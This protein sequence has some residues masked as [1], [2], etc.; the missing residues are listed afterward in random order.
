MLE[1]D[2]RLWNIQFF[3][4]SLLNLVNSLISLKMFHGY[5]NVVIYGN[6]TIINQFLW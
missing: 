1:T 2:M 6:L 5:V 4:N 3:Q